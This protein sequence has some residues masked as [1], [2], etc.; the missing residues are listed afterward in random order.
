[1]RRSS[2]PGNNLGDLPVMALPGDGGQRASL[3]G[4]IDCLRDGQH[5]I[6][7]LVC[8]GGLVNNEPTL[9]L[10]DDAGEKQF[11]SGIDLVNRLV[12][13]PERPRLVVLC[14]ARARR[15]AKARFWRLWAQ[16]WSRQA[17]RRC[18]LCKVIS[19]WRRRSA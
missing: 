3:S 16:S 15:Q 8:H 5:D 11:V 18:W 4:L 13:L 1:M 14:R 7:Y 6:L 19:A 17:S 12:D 2:G 9:L 10:E